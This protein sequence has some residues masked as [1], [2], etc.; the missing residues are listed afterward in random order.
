QTASNN[1][2]RQNKCVWIVNM[3]ELIDKIKAREHNIT[4]AKTL[5]DEHGCSEKQ[6]KNHFDM[7]VNRAWNPHP[8]QDFVK[9]WHKHQDYILHGID[10]VRARNCKVYCQEFLESR[11]YGAS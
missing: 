9:W 5:C 6:R 7:M 1:P 3:N 8:S 10:A 2:K 11:Q 4:R